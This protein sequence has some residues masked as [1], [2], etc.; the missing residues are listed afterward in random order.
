MA[1]FSRER[2]QSVDWN[3][4]GVDIESEKVTGPRGRSIFSWVEEHVSSLGDTFLFCDDGAG[5][6]ADFISANL[7]QTNPVVRFFH[8]K[9]SSASNPGARQDDF[10]I[11][12]CQALRTSRWLNLD[13]L[14]ERLVYRRTTGVRGLLR[15]GDT[16]LRRLAE[17]SMAIR[18][19]FQLFIVQP[20]LLRSETSPQILEFLGG[21]ESWLREG[22]LDRFGVI[23]S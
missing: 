21:I 16:E 7:D 17:P 13:H 4:A 9:A 6:V 3:A 5:E 1:P 11:V 10:Y 23:T 18:V 14:V 2:I 20:G 19:K 12:T 8:C 15:G 22:G